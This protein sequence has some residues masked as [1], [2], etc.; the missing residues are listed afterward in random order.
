MKNMMIIVICCY[1]FFFASMTILTNAWPLPTN[2]SPEFDCGMRKAAFAY[3][4]KLIPRQGEFESL[5]Y[6]LDLNNES[7]V[8]LRVLSKSL[9]L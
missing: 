6:A 2:V 1:Y 3:G 7:L 9:S 8:F 4:K 5:Y